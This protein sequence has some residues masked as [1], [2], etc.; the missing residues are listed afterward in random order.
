MRIVAGTHRGRTLASPQGKNT[1]PTSDRVR[2]SLFNIL[3]HAKWHE[4]SALDDALVL[5]AFAGTGALG[6]EALSRGAANAVFMEKD[7]AAHDICRQNI[8]TLS[9]SARSTTLICDALAP[10]PRPETI[11][12][13]SLVFLDPPYGKGWGSESLQALTAKNWL[14]PKATIIM[15]MAKKQ[16][17]DIPQGFTLHDERSWGI[18]CVLFL[19]AE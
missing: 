17:E 15:E 3:A 2:E 4:S 1:R 9:E 14:A 16:R 7:R 12:P 19:R 5:D 11:A 8:N 10:P 6:L 18:A 13:R